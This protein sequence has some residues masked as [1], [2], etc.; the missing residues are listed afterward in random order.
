[1]VAR[2]AA[3]VAAILMVAIIT[4]LMLMAPRPDMATGTMGMGTGICGTLEVVVVVEWS[5]TIVIGTEIETTWMQ[6]Q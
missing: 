4:I 5:V 3:A 2:V 6:T 1:M